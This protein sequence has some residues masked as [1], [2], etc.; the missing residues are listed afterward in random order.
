MSEQEARWIFL[1]TLR[2]RMKELWV[3]EYLPEIGGP[4]QQA[5]LDVWDYLH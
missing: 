5:L 3:H 4:N 2:W 1:L